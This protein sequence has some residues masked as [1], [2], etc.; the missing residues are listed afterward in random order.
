MSDCCSADADKIYKIRHSLAHIM[1]QAIL[2]IRPQSR[3]AFGPPIENGFYYDFD[4]TTPLTP[5]DFPQIEKIMRRIIS[6]GQ[7]F[8]AFSRP[9]SEAIELLKQQNE[10]YKVEYCQELTD[11]GETGIGFY[12]NGSFEDMCRGP[13]V[14]KTSDIRPDCFA[15]DSIAGAYWRGDE[16]R[17]QLT[18]LYCW[19]FATK[20][21]LDAFLEMRRLAKERDHRKL[22]SELEIFMISDEVGQGLPIWLPNGTVIKD[23]LETFAKEIE[24]QAGYQRVTTPHLAKEGLYYKSG[25]L[26]YYKDVMYPPMQSEGEATYYLKAMNCPHHHTIYGNRPHSYRE[27]PLRL[28][29]YGDCYRHEDSGA[30]SGLLRVRRLSM[31]DAHIYC[32]PDQVEQ[33]FDALID[34]YS[35]YYKKFRI[36]KYKMRLSLHDPANKEKYIDNPEAWAQTEDIIRSI[37]QRK[38]CQF[39]EAIGEA[40]FYGPKIDYQLYNLLGREETASTIQLDFAASGRFNLTF[41]GEDGQ[42]HPLFVVHR[43]PLSTHER[44]ISFLIELY[45]GAFPTWMSPLQTRIIPV[46]PSVLGYAEEIAN[47]LKDKMIRADIDASDDTFNKRIRNAVTHKIPNM[48]IIG[49]KEQD[50]RSVTW[51]RY[52]VKEQQ[53]KE[54]TNYVQLLEAMIKERTMDNFSDEILPTLS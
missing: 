31:N 26:P 44:M 13:H 2:E 45:G 35:F 6:E 40:A 28:A 21:E 12:K 23:A 5:E 51:R 53:T 15:L 9:S 46:N 48:L 24:F 43:A 37:L 32:K 47:L 54:L 50:N 1:A 17:Q 10:I 38:G 34:M 42:E 27:L 33:E 18:R 19:A 16:K 29:E 3:L 52:C 36:Q 14:E 25:H 22:G 4:L 8:T 49:N 20:K 39:E 30:L 7:T 11:K 41:V